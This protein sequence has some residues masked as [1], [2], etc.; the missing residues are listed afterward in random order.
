MLDSIPL[1]F[2]IDKIYLWW[3][4]DKKRDLENEFFDEFVGHSFSLKVGKVINSDDTFA[5]FNDDLVERPQQ[6]FERTENEINFN[7][8]NVKV[9]KENSI[10]LTKLYIK[11]NINYPTRYTATN[12]KKEI[13]NG[14][15]THSVLRLDSDST[16]L[17]NNIDLS[18]Y[19][20]S[21]ENFKD[22]FNTN[23]VV[24]IKAKN[25]SSLKDS[26]NNFKFGFETYFCQSVQNSY[27]SFGYDMYTHRNPNK[28][29]RANIKDFA[30]SI[31]VEDIE[32]HINT[33]I[34]FSL[35]LESWLIGKKEPQ[36]LF[37]L[38]RMYKELKSSFI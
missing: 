30:S 36:T 8:E 4:Y 19:D 37:N 10:L 17:I 38:M 18:I 34:R 14:L 27:N 32:V 16:N 6:E 29:V 1:S 24:I 5:M 33:K 3:K 15:H 21:I 7:I 11:S 2:F 12:D 23:F 9:E 35:L 25:K 31:N 22:G 28:E 26:L 13:E 20:I